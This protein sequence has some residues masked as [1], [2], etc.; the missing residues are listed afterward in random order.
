MPY[1]DKEPGSPWR[2]GSIMSPSRQI[3]IRTYMS[4]DISVK[5][6]VSK[7]WWAIPC[8]RLACKRAR[9]FNIHLGNCLASVMAGHGGMGACN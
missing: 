6:G 7:T 2:Y 4:E 5:G 1:C 9:T 3:L 8:Q